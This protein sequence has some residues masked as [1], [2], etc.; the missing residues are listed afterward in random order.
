MNKSSV[1]SKK[2]GSKIMNNI[3]KKSLIDTIIDLNIITRMIN[4]DFSSDIELMQGVDRIFCEPLE[5]EEG[6]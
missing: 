6:W 4:R 5:K 2:G 3:T 1:L